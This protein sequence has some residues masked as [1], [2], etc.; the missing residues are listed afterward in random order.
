L[1]IPIFASI[2]EIFLIKKHLIFQLKLLCCNG[3]CLPL[4]MI[5]VENNDEIIQEESKDFPE[6]AIQKKL[7]QCS[8]YES[9][10]EF[11]L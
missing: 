11:L 2:D 4:Q 1:Q 8:A 6:F 3:R 10:E 7:E 9:V 5:E